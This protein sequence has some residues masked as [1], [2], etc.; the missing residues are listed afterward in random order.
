MCLVSHIVSAPAF[1]GG[2][3]LTRGERT[4]NAWSDAPRQVEKRKSSETNGPREDVSN[5]VPIHIIARRIHALLP[6]RPKTPCHRQKKIEGNM[7][8]LLHPSGIVVD[9][10]RNFFSQPPCVVLRF[11]AHLVTTCKMT[12]YNQTKKRKGKEL[13]G[14]VRIV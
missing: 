5:S 2:R 14:I 1:Q 4:D 11:D 8:L 6:A 13:R 9:R 3:L 10:N 7:V 12:Q